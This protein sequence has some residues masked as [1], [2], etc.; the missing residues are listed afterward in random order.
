[1]D[2]RLNSWIIG[3][4][5]FMNQTIKINLLMYESI[6]REHFIKCGYLNKNTKN[7]ED[8][9]LTKSASKSQLIGTTQI[10]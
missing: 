1:M 5:I 9:L 4:Y 6:F 7:P 10:L 8:I 2:R 3:L